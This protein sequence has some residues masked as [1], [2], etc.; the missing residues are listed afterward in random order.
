MN[1]Q[2][3]EYAEFQPVPWKNG[4]GKAIVLAVHPADASMENFAWRVS[5]AE[6]DE[7][8]AYSLFPGLNRTQIL[9]TGQG[10]HLKGMQQYDLITAYDVIDFDG[11]SELSCELVSGACRVLNIMVRRSLAAAEVKVVRG[12]GLMQLVG[13]NHLFYV[14]FGKYVLS[15]TH[16]AAIHI[17]SG[18]GLLIHE[19]NVLMQASAGEEAVLIVVSLRRII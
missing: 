19:R 2:P 14:A 15:S 13:D 1:V 8:V 16:A 4:A 12:S 10:L 17:K 18:D 7:A 3:L 6:I 9:L 5:I 11:E